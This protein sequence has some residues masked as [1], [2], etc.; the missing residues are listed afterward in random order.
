MI[1]IPHV[2]ATQWIRFVNQPFALVLQYSRVWTGQ[3]Y[4]EISHV[5]QFDALIAWICNQVSLEVLT[6]FW[7]LDPVSFGKL[8]LIAQKKI[9]HVCQTLIH[10]LYEC[11]VC[12]N[13]GLVWR[14]EYWCE[15]FFFSLALACW[16]EWFKWE[17][18]LESRPSKS[19]FNLILL[20]FKLPNR[21][22]DDL[23]PLKRR[24]INFVYQP[25]W[26]TG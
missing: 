1:C 13:S 25:K 22:L 17:F 21:E 18:D 20:T 2:F 23:M 8:N 11:F 26:K 15:C 4:P 10:C 19:G 6:P 7:N 16:C 14:T 3:K 12:K 24:A 9:I 5:Q